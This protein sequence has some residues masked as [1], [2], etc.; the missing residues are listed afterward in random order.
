M[1]EALPALTFGLINSVTALFGNPPPI[2]RSRKDIPVLKRVAGD[3]GACGKRSA[4]NFRR[5]TILPV[6]TIAERMAYSGICSSEHFLAIGLSALPPLL[7][8]DQRNHYPLD[9]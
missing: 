6:A 7:F 8:A 1:S 3:E 9:L 4:S 5:S 2:V